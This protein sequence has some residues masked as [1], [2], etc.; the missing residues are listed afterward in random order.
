MNPCRQLGRWF[1]RLC[2]A[3]QS[4]AA[5]FDEQ[6]HWLE[7]EPDVRVCIN[8]P[9]PAGRPPRNGTTLIFYA[10][11]NGNTIEQTLGRKPQPGQDWHFD[12]QHI[13]AQT[14]F[15]RERI[16]DRAL[17][18]VCLE[19]RFKSWPAWRR[20]HGDTR[21]GGLLEQIAGRFEHP[22]TEWVLT[23][24]SGGGSLT[25]GFLDAVTRIPERVSRIAFLDSN[26]AFDP[27][28]GHGEK[29]ARWLQSGP[30][31]FLCVLAYDDAAA[32]LDGKPFVSARG[33]TWGR[34]HAML[35]ELEKH[36]A[37]KRE[38]NGPLEIARALD[39]RVQFALRHN[40]EG[41]IWHTVLVERNGFIHAM[42]SGTPLEG[43]GYE[44]LGPRAYERWIA[45][46]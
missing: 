19:N 12:I 46:E 11:P 41:R 8:E 28:L 23:G 7:L 3:A 44:F 24:H 37:F 33:G 16:S 13:A 34:S 6:V 2:L 20:Q 40:P 10:L 32:R 15:L 29:L 4:S 43:R 1:L 30:E 36:F 5:T 25:F 18:L 38:R 45:S 26:Y 31:R 14:R 39:G 27:A 22:A 35:E 21:I 17:V 42:V 9:G